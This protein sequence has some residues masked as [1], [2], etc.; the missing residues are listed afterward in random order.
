MRNLIALKSLRDRSLKQ[1]DSLS[2]RPAPP[3][4]KSSIVSLIILIE[5]CGVFSFLAFYLVLC[6]SLQ[7][8][9]LLYF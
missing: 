7:R 8:C 4:F 2:L 3:L 5:Y 1:V 6:L 9:E